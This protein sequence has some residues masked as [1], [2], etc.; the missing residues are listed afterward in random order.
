MAVF[1]DAVA[2]DAP[3]FS[4]SEGRRG[5]ENRTGKTS[6]RLVQ[7]GGIVKGYVMEI[8]ESTIGAETVPFHFNDDPFSVWE[9]DLTKMVWPDSKDAF[10]SYG[11][12]DLDRVLN[13]L[14][15]GD[16]VLLDG[17]MDCGKS[18][19]A[20]TLGHT[21]SW[22]QKATGIFFAL[23][24][25]ARSLHY[26]HGG[27]DSVRRYEVTIIAVRLNRPDAPSCPH[28]AETPAWKAVGFVYSLLEY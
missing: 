25:K 9:A 2:V 3:R 24:T 10:L 26:T 5:M 20:E 8:L 13:G 18:D 16:L 12:Y 7:H 22:R 19:F 4:S 1:Q 11:L 17:K 6:R 23:G 21:H 14:H 15:R 28:T 27:K